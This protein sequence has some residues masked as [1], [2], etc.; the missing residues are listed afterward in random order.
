MQP[1]SASLRLI[2]ALHDFQTGEKSRG[3]EIDFE[4]CNSDAVLKSWQNTVYL[5]DVRQVT[6][7]TDL[8]LWPQ[9]EHPEAFFR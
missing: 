9:N 3:C 1:N 6:T 2:L 7:K 8:I 5:A 4:H